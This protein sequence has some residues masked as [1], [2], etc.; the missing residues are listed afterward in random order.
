MSVRTSHGVLRVAVASSALLALG[1]AKHGPSLPPAAGEGA[2]PP[3]HI[4]TPAPA[5]ATDPLASTSRASTGTLRARETAA[6]GPKET[7]VITMLAVDEGDRV[8]KGQLLFKLDSVQVALAV[9]QARLAV[10]SAQVQLDSAQTDHQRIAA[11]RERGSV[12]AEVF[13]QSKSRLDAAKSMVDQARAAL[14]MAQHRVTNMVVESPIDGIVTER[15]MNLGETATLMPPTVVLVIQDIDALE[16][17]ARLPEAG[18]ETLREGSPVDLRFPAIGESRQVKIKRI[19]PVVDARTRT[20]E[21]IADIDN[22]NH[23]LLAGMAV[24]VSYQK[25]GTAGTEDPHAP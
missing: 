19:A 17:R 18:L 21:I 25:T 5:A 12:P 22:T 2:P 11:L 1:C 6:L 7:G 16:L 20:I 9:E 10:A 15:R 4:A 23:R 14:G 8:K 24:E 13:D 3:A